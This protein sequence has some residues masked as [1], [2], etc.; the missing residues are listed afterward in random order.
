MSLEDDTFDDDDDFDLDKVYSNAHQTQQ[1]LAQSQAS[2]QV[3][4]P[5]QEQSKINKNKNSDDIYQI[6]GENAVLRGKLEKI[7]KDQS[8]D[9][10]RIKDDFDKLLKE[11]ESYIEALNETILK[12]KSE[13]EFLVS[14]NKNLYQSNSRKR[15]KRPHDNSNLSNIQSQH[16]KSAETSTSSYSTSTQNFSLNN[17]DDIELIEDKI[18]QPEVKVVVMKQATFFQDE[19]TLFIEAITNYVIPGMSKPTL[20]YLENIN[21]SFTFVSNDFKILVHENSFKSAILKYLIN[22]Q[23]RNRIDYLL[24]RFIGILLEYITLNFEREDAQLLPIPFLLSLVNFSL[25]YKPK[26]VDTNLLKSTTEKIVSMLKYFQEIFKPEFDYLSLP[27]SNYMMNFATI[28]D[29]QHGELMDYDFI[30]KP[31]HVKILEVFTAIFLMDI[32]ATLSK[33]TSLHMLTFSNSNANSLFWNKVPQQLLINSF[34]SRKTPVHFV[35]DTVEILLNSIVDDDKFAFANTRKNSIMKQ[36][37]AND[38]TIQILE[39]SMKFLIS[40]SPDQIHFNVYGLNKLIGANNHLKLLE[41]VSIPPDKLASYPT[42]NSFDDYEQALQETPNCYQRQELYVLSTKILILDLFEAFYTNL[43]MISLPLNTNLRLVRILCQLI[44][45]EQDI[46]IR[47]PRGV[48][49]YLRI[50][51]I[52]K[53]VKIIHHLIVHENSVKVGELPNL[54]LREMIIVLLR[55]SSKSI[56]NESI[57]YVIAL[58]KNMNYNGV[59]FNGLKESEELDK[60]GIWN[61]ILSL[62]NLDLNEQQKITENRIQI[63][64]DLYNGIEF[65]YSDEIIDLARDIIGLCVTPN[66]AESLHKS[67]NYFS[68]YEDEEDYENLL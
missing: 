37:V 21:S 46:I 23:D 41:M 5:T 24:T 58:R 18:M 47:S 50:D 43:L 12:M 8:E 4:K 10:R 34:L 38:I 55:I 56:K 54:V 66:E 60:Y 39:Q 59:L 52:S 33:I 7:Q 61:S 51:I 35:Y 22:F 62:S 11:K 57:N 19:K 25:Y 9:Q 64:I 1:L 17:D 68:L 31:M 42:T 48:N 63:E 45:E 27:S 14:E 30:E 53:A 67:I 36:K 6:K 20:S 2:R 29:K 65:N 49:N 26:A 16:D 28:Q 13:N 44:G 15:K 40:I 32:F 3:Q